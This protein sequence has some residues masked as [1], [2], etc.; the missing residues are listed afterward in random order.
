MFDRI[1]SLISTR[2]QQGDHGE[3]CCPVLNRKICRDFNLG[4]SLNVSQSDG[5]VVMGVDRKSGVERAVKVLETKQ[6]HSEVDV[7]V[8]AK[9][10]NLVSAVAVYEQRKRCYLVM[11]KCGGGDIFDAVSENR[12]KT[13]VSIARVIAQ[14]LEGLSYLHEDLGFAHCDVKLCNIML[15]DCSSRPTVKLID[16]GMAQRL[17]EKNFT[18]LL[19]SPSF[20]A[21]EVLAKSYNERSDLWSLGV[22]TFIMLFGFNPFNPRGRIGPMSTEKIWRS[23]RTGFCDEVRPGFGAFFPQRKVISCNAR[24]FITTLLC[25]DP[26]LRPSASQALQHPW[27]VASLEPGEQRWK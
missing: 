24:A 23:I 15:S 21:P 5:E 4:R 27:I 10:K 18:R 25:S 20:L 22:V 11:E 8:R 1:I 6:V 17:T 2:K 19:G 3:G 26:L 12:F 9:H 16:F 13:E 7:A 14:V